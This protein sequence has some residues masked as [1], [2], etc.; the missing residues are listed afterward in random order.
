M[1]ALCLLKCNSYETNCKFY[2]FDKADVF[3]EKSRNL[4][5][6][7]ESFLVSDSWVDIEK[8]IDI[9]DKYYISKFGHKWQ[10]DRLSIQQEFENEIIKV[11]PSIKIL[12]NSERQP[13]YD[14]SEGW[15]TSKYELN[16]HLIVFR[17]P[18]WRDYNLYDVT[19]D[20]IGGYLINICTDYRRKM[21]EIFENIKRRCSEVAV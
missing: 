17:L 5:L 3:F 11:F 1:N 7:Y 19:I 13:P 6:D 18:D 10:I 4:L 14:Y 20:N 12:Y 16:N 9:M 15:N 21:K 2:P 8:Y